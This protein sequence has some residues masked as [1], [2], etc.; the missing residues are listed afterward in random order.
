MRLIHKLSRINFAIVLI[1]L[2]GAFNFTPI[3]AIS[4]YNKKLAQ[5]IIDPSKLQLQPVI[6]GLTQP[7]LITHADDGSDR[8]FIIERAGKIRLAK[9]NVL[10]STPFLDMQSIV[11]SASSER[12]LLALAFHP[13]FASN[14][15]LYT[16]HTNS[17][18]S[19]VLS[20][21]TAS[22][23]T[24]D[25]VSFGSRVE[26]LVIPHPTY[27]NHNGGTLA[28]GPDGY[29]YWSTGDGGGAGDP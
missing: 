6:S 16:V 7:V 17:S 1:M 2:H 9:N 21:F 26:L 29:L 13:Q 8:L 27:G 5:N 23:A 4:N 20:R 3:I 14:G 10:L 11:N 18:G 19:L 28:F 12:G 25:Q 22:P 24:T 15:Y